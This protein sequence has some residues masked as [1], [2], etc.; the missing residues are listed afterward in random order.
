MNGKPIFP[1]SGSFGVASAA[2]ERAT[3][4]ANHVLSAEPVACARLK[5]H[6][7][8][9]IELELRGWPSPLPP[10]PPLRFEVTPAGLLDWLGEQPGADAALVIGVDAS[11]PAVLAARGLAGQRPEVDL[12]G[13]AALAA[14]VNWLIDNVRW[15]VRDDLQR[16][17]GPAAA[18][19]IGRAGS[20]MAQGVRE[21]LRRVSTQAARRAG[22]GA[23]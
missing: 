11:N 14:D 1:A 2:V 15:D 20:A 4:L 5:A 22:P 12:Q 8:R 21:V 16:V 19:Q 7:G 3:L 13:D 6:A 23:G 17:V 9:V 10:C 18:E